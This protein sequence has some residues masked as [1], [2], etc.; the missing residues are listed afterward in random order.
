L[1]EVPSGTASKFYIPED[2]AEFFKALKWLE[3]KL[4]L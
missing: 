4:A 3:T 1:G 2:D